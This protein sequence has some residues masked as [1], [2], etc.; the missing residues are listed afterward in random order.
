MDVRQFK[1]DI[2]EDVRVNWQELTP[3]EVMVR[4]VT[5]DTIEVRLTFDKSLSFTYDLM[6]MGY[7]IEKIVRLAADRSKLENMRETKH[8]RAYLTF[9]VDD[10]QIELGLYFSH[11][12]TPRIGDD[13]FRGLLTRDDEWGL[14]AIED[15][16]I[17]EAKSPNSE[18]FVF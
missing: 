7:E 4:F 6:A 13:K 8:S 5:H 9:V 1:S 14:G 17:I 11:K 10:D 18:P 15:I 3:L 2:D 16:K 12:D